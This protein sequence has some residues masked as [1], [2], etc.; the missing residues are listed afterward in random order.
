MKDTAKFIDLID[1]R[2]NK[3][4]DI[5]NIYKYGKKLEISRFI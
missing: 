2:R 4:Y 1:S 5:Y 3:K